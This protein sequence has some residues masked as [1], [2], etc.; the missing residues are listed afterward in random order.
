MGNF[1]LQRQVAQCLI[2]AVSG[3]SLSLL[4]FLMLAF[5][6]C[7]NGYAQQNV[8]TERFNMGVY[9]PSIKNIVSRKDFEVALNFWIEEVSHLIAFKAV[10]ARLFDN[11]TDMRDAL[12][13][14]DLDFVLAPPILM[15]NI[16]ARE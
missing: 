16:F 13:Q 6:F 15:A 8:A 10:N 1:Q 11:I 3:R 7:A 12:M 14:N 5:C 9:Y 2:A 4:F